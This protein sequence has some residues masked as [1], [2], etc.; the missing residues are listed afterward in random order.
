MNDI[1]TAITAVK[2][3]QRYFDGRL[4]TIADQDGRAKDISIEEMKLDLRIIKHIRLRNL[5]NEG[6][7]AA[8]LQLTMREQK[9]QDSLTRLETFGM[10]VRKTR[11]WGYRG[12]WVD[13]APELREVANT[14]TGD[15]LSIDV[16]EVVPDLVKCEA[17]K[18]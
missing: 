7:L 2:D 10:I 15:G 13:L 16:A 1:N 12:A 18:E 11:E 17:K 14:A 4:R 9:F 5:H 6:Q 3:K 8:Y